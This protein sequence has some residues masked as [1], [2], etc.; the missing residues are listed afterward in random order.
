MELDLRQGICDN[1]QYNA[2][3]FPGGE[4]H[5]KIKDFKKILEFNGSVN[6]VTRLN[7]SD[8]IILLLLVVDTI[9][10]VSVNQKIE[11]F[12]PYMP[13]QQ[14]DRKFSDGECFSLKSIA[15]I[16]NSMRFDKVKIFDSH[17]DVSLALINNSEGIDNS[18]FISNVILDL[19]NKGIST[20]DIILLSPD[21]GA[22]KKIFK[23]SEKICFT[24]QVETCSKSRNGTTQEITY[25]VPEFNKDKVVLIC[26][27]ICL[28]GR[29][30]IN[31]AKVIKNPCY[32]AVSHGIFNSGG[33]GDPI[34]QLKAVFNGIYTTNS[35]GEV[36]SNDNINIINI[37]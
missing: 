17:S 26:D 6:I 24:G 12:I 22:F 20:D 35:R 25:R 32:L 21:A 14:A 37:F 28:G 36:L 19:S 3:K 23:I 4:I 16:I 8:D 18:K 34:P 1:A 2:W 15:N 5:V 33:Y 31:I 7:S 11:L 10:E 30:F 27:D 9:R 13:Y 29:T